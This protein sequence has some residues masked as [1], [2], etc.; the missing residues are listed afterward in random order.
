MFVKL[1]AP[2]SHLAVAVRV[3]TSYAVLSSKSIFPTNLANIYPCVKTLIFFV[4]YTANH[5]HW[6][7]YYI[8]NK[9]KKRVE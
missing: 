2:V 5:T 7:V 8:E 3:S 6:H 1:G 9:H 4:N